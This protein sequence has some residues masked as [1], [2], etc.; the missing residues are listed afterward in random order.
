[1][2]I[3]LSPAASRRIGRVAIFVASEILSGALVAMVAAI[4]IC[5]AI[6][7]DFPM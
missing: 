1:M 7:A 2:R 5:D 3:S 4:C 6:G